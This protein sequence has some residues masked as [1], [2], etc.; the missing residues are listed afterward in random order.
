M[1]PFIPSLARYRRWIALALAAMTAGVVLPFVSRL[2]QVVIPGIPE[3][4]VIGPADPYV[5]AVI[6]YLV[7]N[8]LAKR[9]FN[10]IILKTKMAL[11]QR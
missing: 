10:W 9:F 8:F 3:P 6:S 5:A 2:D 1:I 7:V 4:Y 11:S